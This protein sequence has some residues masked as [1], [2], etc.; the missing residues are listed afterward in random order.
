MYVLVT[1][2]VSVERMEMGGRYCEFTHHKVRGMGK[3]PES[4]IRGFLPPPRNESF[5]FYP[6]LYMCE[7]YILFFEF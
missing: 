3:N 4:E 7:S 6:T 1:A 2:G 5:C